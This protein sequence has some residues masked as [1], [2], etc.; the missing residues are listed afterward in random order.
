MK[1]FHDGVVIASGFICQV[2]IEY[3]TNSY[4]F[5]YYTGQ[6]V[7]IDVSRGTSPK[8]KIKYIHTL[9]LASY[10]HACNYINYKQINCF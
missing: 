9:R 4:L 5:I 3:N 10:L 2:M 8:R 7:I 1:P 6:P